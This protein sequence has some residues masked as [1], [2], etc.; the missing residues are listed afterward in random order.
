MVVVLKRRHPA[1][2]A[3]WARG[4]VKMNTPAH[5]SPVGQ[6]VQYAVANYR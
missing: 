3:R 1:V 5:P 2:S 4:T 6:Q